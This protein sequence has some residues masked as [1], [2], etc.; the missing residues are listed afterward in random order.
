VLNFVCGA[1]VLKKRGERKKKISQERKR[2]SDAGYTDGDDVR[3]D[4]GWVC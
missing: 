2:G 4:W 1:L 3:A